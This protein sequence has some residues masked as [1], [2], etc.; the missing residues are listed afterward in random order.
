MPNIMP[1][2]AIWPQRYKKKMI[3]ANDIV[4]KNGLSLTNV[5]FFLC[6]VSF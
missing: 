2:L 6:I 3:Y 1:Y 4:E 5:D